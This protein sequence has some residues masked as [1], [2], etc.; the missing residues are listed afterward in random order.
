MNW[1][2]YCSIIFANHGE[3]II[4]IKFIW[5]KLDVKQSSGRLKPDSCKSHQHKVDRLT[6]YSLQR[7]TPSYST[8]ASF[9]FMSCVLADIKLKQGP[10]SATLGLSDII[11]QASLML[12]VSVSSCLCEQLQESS[13]V[14]LMNIWRNAWESLTAEIK[15][16]IERLINEKHCQ[17]YQWLILLREITEDLTMLSVCTVVNSVLVKFLWC[18]TERSGRVLNTPASYSGGSNLGPDT[19]YPD[20]WFS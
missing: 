15:P 11:K 2:S 4:C 10:E 5:T 13:R 6:P 1:K 18:S 8:I 12:S 14:L 20:T 7:Q 3:S 19:C 17:I 9:E 16:D